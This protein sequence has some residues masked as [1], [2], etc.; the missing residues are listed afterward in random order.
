MSD[1]I[2]Q[3]LLIYVLSNVPNV[4]IL[5]SEPEREKIFGMRTQSESRGITLLTVS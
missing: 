2:N 4:R 5:Y 3:I 1:I